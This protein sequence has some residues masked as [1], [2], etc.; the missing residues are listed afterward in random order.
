MEKVMLSYSLKTV[1]ALTALLAT[2][3]FLVAI[4]SAHA[5]VCSER[6]KFTTFLSKKYK[7]MPKAVGLVSNTGMM[8]VYV[9]EQGT[10]SILMTT[11]NGITCLIAA[12]DHWEGLKL[13][14]ID[15]PS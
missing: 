1:S 12:G 13:A 11:P 3:F 2:S 7:E 10:W 4:Q 9:S 5:A 6:K 8:E 15:T 14:K